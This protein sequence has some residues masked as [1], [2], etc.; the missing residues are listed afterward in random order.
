MAITDD[1]E[2]PERRGKDCL[3][4]IP[5]PLNVIKE[6]IILRGES[7]RTLRLDIFFSSVLLVV[8]SI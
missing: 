2:K 6:R 3:G 5:L 8:N 1:S 4:S 7:V